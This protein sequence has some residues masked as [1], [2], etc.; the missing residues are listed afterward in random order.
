MRQNHSV[1]VSRDKEG[2]VI[3]GPIRALLVH[4]IPSLQH[5]DQSPLH[6]NAVASLTLSWWTVDIL[7]ASA[8]VLTD[9]MIDVHG[10]KRFSTF[11]VHYIVIF[12]KFLSDKNFSRETGYV[13]FSPFPFAP[14]SFYNNNVTKLHLKKKNKKEDKKK[15]SRQTFKLSSSFKLYLKEPRMPFSP[16][17][18]CKG[19]L[20]RTDYRQLC[21]VSKFL[22]WR[23][24]L[25]WLSV[26]PEV[27][28]NIRSQQYTN[29]WENYLPS[30]YLVYHSYGSCKTSPV[31][32]VL[33]C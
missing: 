2:F 7:P 25:L 29:V 16:F 33:S 20:H 15:K 24:L 30:Q 17:C 10:L 31:S 3:T 11:F 27:P 1:E 22:F 19:F 26:L 13:L 28:A 5:E 21:I 12:Q 9:H 8:N 4:L 14:M 32:S 6:C 23:G 18:A